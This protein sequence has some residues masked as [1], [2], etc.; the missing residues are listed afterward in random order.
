MHFEIMPAD[1]FRWPETELSATIDIE[2]NSNAIILYEPCVIYSCI[3]RN[4]LHFNFI[5]FAC[6]LLKSVDC[7]LATYLYCTPYN[8]TFTV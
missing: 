2:I 7:C 6:Q 3:M 8:R 1:K 4:F 5:H